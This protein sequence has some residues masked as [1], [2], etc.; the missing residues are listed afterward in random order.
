MDANASKPWLTAPPNAPAQN[1]QHPLQLG[2]TTAL[3]TLIP[4]ENQTVH[5]LQGKLYLP[6]PTGYMAPVNH[7][8]IATHQAVHQQPAGDDTPDI[9]STFLLAP[10]GSNGVQ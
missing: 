6:Q 1:I 3:Q 5:I 10:P 4:V 8:I 9:A 7:E 2:G